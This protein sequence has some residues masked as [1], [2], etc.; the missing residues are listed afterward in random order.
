M[1]DASVSKALR[2]GH[3]LVVVE[4]PAGCGKTHQGSL[5]AIDAAHGLQGDGRVLIL[6]HTHAAC[7]VFA[8][9]TPNLRR[10]V[11]VRTID[12]LIVEIAAAYHIPLDLPADPGAWARAQKDGYG[13]VAGK[14]ARLMAATP[15]IERMLARRFPII[16]C[17]EHQ[18]ASSDQH[19]ITMALLRGGAALR[20]FGDPMQRIYGSSSRKTAVAFEADWSTLKGRGV[21][22]E[23]DTP[24]RWAS[25][26]LLGQWV[27]AARGTLR[28]GGQLDLTSG[29]PAS[30]TVIRAENIAPMARGYSA[31][32]AERRPI[33]RVVHSAAELLVLTPHNDLVLALR[34]FFN[35]AL[36]I[37]EG[38]VRDALDALAMS[39]REHDGKPC[40]V[41]EAL[42]AFLGEVCKGFSPSA[43]GDA[44][45]AE[46][47]SGCCHPRR[48]KPATLQALARMLLA[49][50]NHCGVAK[51]LRRLHTLVESDAAF[52]SIC[53]DY[54][55]EY[56]D[57]VLLADYSSPDAGVTDLAQRRSARHPKPP[58]K[59]ISTVH[60]AKGLECPNVII[61]PCDAT[62]FPDTPAARRKLYVAMS[63]ATSSL[64][65]VVPRAGRSPLLF[66]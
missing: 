20:I 50:P 63:R 52:G 59:A 51:V 66:A 39:L 56:W 33:D 47:Q 53:I 28:D 57:A 23:L 36:P 40:A 16:I 55:R 25:D 21:T 45:I 27:L 24:H 46:V 26:P 44:L 6:A 35:R 62:R 1:S 7:D 41:A 32:P 43:F 17:D 3:P 18:D 49:E 65:L 58:A 42:V 48:G 60:K 34:A 10:R 15:V 9:R 38:H 14:V 4:A 8:S 12:S 13:K 61:V 29:V 22:E 31:G 54:Q 19:D 37:W 11:E 2:S 5:F 64:T 30:V